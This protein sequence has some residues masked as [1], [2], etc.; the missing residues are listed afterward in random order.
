MLRLETRNPNNIDQVGLGGC[1]P[2]ARPVLV[3]IARVCIASARSGLMERALCDLW[4]GVSPFKQSTGGLMPSVM[5]CQ[6]DNAEHVA[7]PGEIMSNTMILKEDRPVHSLGVSQLVSGAPALNEATVASLSKHGIDAP[8]SQLTKPYA[9]KVAPLLDELFAP[10]PDNSPHHSN[11]IVVI[12]RDGNIAATNHQRCRLGRYGYRCRRHCAQRRQACTGNR[13]YR[14]VAGA[15]KPSRPY[16]GS[17]PEAELA[18]VDGRARA[19]VAHR[20][21]CRGANT[22]IHSSLHPAR[23]LYTSVPRE[24]ESRG[25]NRTPE[26]CRSAGR[27]GFQRIAVTVPRTSPLRAVGHKTWLIERYSL[28]TCRMTVDV[29]LTEIVTFEEKMSIK[30]ARQCVRKAVAELEP[31][32]V[33]FFAKLLEGPTGEVSLIFIDGHEGDL[34]FGDEQIEISNAVRAIAGLNDH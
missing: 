15:G 32:R 11:S 1:G 20:L 5:E 9:Q 2:G 17:R 28:T 30:R 29:R 21:Q 6:V 8:P 19:V 7:R 24:S 26:C 25:E 3:V 14:R 31:S 33:A 16:R 4:N 34:R 27:D 23:H 22:R 12:D 10:A 13:Q 18:N